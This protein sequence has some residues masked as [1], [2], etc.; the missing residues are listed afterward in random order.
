MALELEVDKLE[1]VPAPLREYYLPRDGKF[2]LDVPIA[3]LKSAL[4][5][6][7]EANRDIKKALGEHNLTAA[8]IPSLV[9][10][11][12]ALID[13]QAKLRDLQVN[14]A[15]TIALM[16]AKPTA[17]GA[18]LLPSLLQKRVTVETIDGADIFRIA[19]KD[20]RPMPGSGSDGLATF[21]DLVKETIGRYGD[22]FEATGAGGGGAPTRGARGNG[23]PPKTI[24][25][26]DFDKMSPVD[27]HTKI[28]KEGYSVVDG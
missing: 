27:R 19:D 10:S 20:G 22:L 7:T 8:D 21:D 23:L 28:V 14:H 4:Q 12:K 25:R 26:S 18:D 9:N 1:S 2:H 11:N 24:L 13:T 15:V 5:K 6:Q 3:G 17:T 16:R